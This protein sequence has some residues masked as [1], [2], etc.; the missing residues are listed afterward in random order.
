MEEIPKRSFLSVEMVLLALSCLTCELQEQQP[1]TSLLPQAESESRVP[2]GQKAA[3][4]S[5]CDIVS[6]KIM[7]S[8]SQYHLIKFSSN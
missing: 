2:L 4:C 3:G 7:A 6:F 8:S 5:S 1:L